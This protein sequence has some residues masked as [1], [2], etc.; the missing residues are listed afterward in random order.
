MNDKLAIHGGSPI[1]TIDDPEQWRRPIQ[2]EMK[3]IKLPF[4]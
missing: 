2:R 1:V 3:L 4:V